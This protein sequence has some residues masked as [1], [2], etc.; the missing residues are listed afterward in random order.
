MRKCGNI[1]QYMRRPSVIYDFAPDPAEFPYIRGK[2]YLLFY[3][4]NNLA[5]RRKTSG[6]EFKS[7]ILCKNYFNK[8]KI[9]IKANIYL[10]SVLTK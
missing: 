7:Y 2:F 3:Q 4:C 10:S 6:H 8:E 1:S 5:G 9:I